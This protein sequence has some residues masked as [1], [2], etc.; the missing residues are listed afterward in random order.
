MEIGALQISIRRIVMK[1][2]FAIIALSLLSI[3]AFADPC[4]E[5]NVSPGGYTQQEI[6]KMHLDEEG[7]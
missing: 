5:A 3:G 2:I 4:M 7:C 6:D 1:K